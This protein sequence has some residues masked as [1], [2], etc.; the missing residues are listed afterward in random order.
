MRTRTECTGFFRAV[1]LSVAAATAPA[2]VTAAQQ[3]SGRVAIDADDL[4]GVVTSSNGPEA[5]VW[6]LAE[7]AD[8][9]TPYRK[10]VVTDDQGRYVVPDLPEARYRVW[11]R[12]YGLVDSPKVDAEPGQVLDLTAVL[13]PDEAAA[14]EYYPASYWYSLVEI[15]AASE[16]PGTG[17]DGNGISTEMTSQ[18]DWIAAMK[19]NCIPCHQLGTKATR[20]ILPALRAS[21]DS[22]LEAWEHRTQV[23]QQAPLMTSLLNQFGRQ[24]ALRMF[25]DWTDRITAG[26][27][28]PAPPRPQG[29]ERHFVITQWDWATPVN[30][31]HDVT[32][33]D[34]RNPTLNAYGKVYSNNRHNQPVLNELDPVRHTVRQVA[35]L[36]VRDPDTPFSTPQRMPAPSPY[37]G[38]ELIWSAQSDSHNLMMDQDGRV[39][40]TASIRQP[41]TPAWCREGSDHPAAQFFPL[42]RSGRQFARY[43]PR[44]EEIALIDTC[45]STHHLFFDDDPDSKLWGSASGYVNTRRFDETGDEVRAN[46]WM[47][48]VVDTNGNGRQDPYVEPDEP[49]Q[50]D[51]DKRVNGSAYGMTP[52]ALDDAMWGFGG[53]GVSRLDPGP[54]PPR[55]ALGELYIPDGVGYQIR[56]GYLDTNDIAWVGLMSGHLGRF[57][58]RQ[59]QTRSGPAAATGLHCPE[60]WTYYQTPGP[61]FGNA[62]AST[63]SDMHYHTWVDRYNTLGLGENIPIVMG[64][65]S[66]STIAF[67]PETEEFLRIRMPYP[68]NFHTR[69]GDGRIDD[70]DAGWKGRGMWQSYSSF[71]P[72]HAEGGQDDTPKAVHLQYRP[73]PLAK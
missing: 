61:T 49:V 67:L 15:P 29:R 56:G 48:F 73:H 46:M 44:T 37:W 28:P 68:R 55:T 2:C 5:G 13:A 4:G 17:R 6:V 16:F 18:A 20:E 23:G 1:A 11:V 35:T 9:P 45:F 30:Y 70:P 51:K 64:S 60:G 8:L 14:A 24:R 38:E 66:D 43:D 27:L 32:S 39:W 65:N 21:F 71:A 63:N 33:T 59:C 62:P 42:D 3:S 19:R 72:W 7:T 54:N 31:I 10:I 52:S 40:I 58:R 41:P 36:P 53:G 47:P 50:P 26:A 25:A 34:L 69:L 12:G 22:T 57:D